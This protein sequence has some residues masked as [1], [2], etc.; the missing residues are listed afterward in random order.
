[1]SWKL[2]IVESPSKAKTIQK[3]LGKSY[4]V[5][6]SFGHVRD[7]L[8]KNK[9]VE[10]HD[11]EVILHYVDGEKSV[12]HLKAI[13]A[14][15]KKTETLI[16]ATDPDR[17]G[18]AIAFHVVEYLKQH[19]DINKIKIERVCFYEITPSKVKDAIAQSRDI[20]MDLVD[21]QQ[22]RRALDYLVGF[23]LSPVLWKKVGPK[24]SAGRVQ[25][26]ALRM[27]KERDDEIQKFKPK[28]YW[29]L[30][31]LLKAG[32]IQIESVTTHLSGEKLKKFS[33]SNEEK[34]VTAKEAITAQSKNTCVV[35][36]IKSK[37]RQRKPAPP[38]I[39]ST[40]Q[41][42][43]ARKLGFSALNTMRIAQQL[44]EGIDRGEST[45][46]LITYMRTDSVTLSGDAIK[47]SRE[48]I[49]SFYGKD[50]LPAK[51]NTYKSKSK[52]AQE[53]HEAIRPVDFSVDPESIKKTLSNDQY[54]LYRLIWVRALASQMKAATFEDQVMVF[55]AK[56]DHLFE[57]RRSQPVFMGFL[58]VYQEGEDEGSKISPAVRHDKFIDLKE[59]ATLSIEDIRPDQHFTE[60]P[61]RFSEASLVKELE[62]KG[63]GRPSTY[64]SII[65]TL[66]AREYVELKQKRFYPTDV[67]SIV[68]EFLNKYFSQYVDYGFTAD[69]ENILDE[70]SNGKRSWQE[71]IRDFWSP[72]NA[73]VDHITENVSKKEVTE[74]K[75]DEKC[76]ECQAD[77]VKKFGKM[78][79]FIACSAYPDCK[80]T[81]SMD[82]ES[83]SDLP[84]IDRACPKC[85][86]PLTYKRGRYGVFIGCTGY[87]DCRHIESIKEKA[88]DQKTGVT[89][90]ECNKGEMVKK[91]SRR[92]TF[93]YSC[94]RY[95]DCKTALSGFPV[96]KQ[97]P[98]CQ[99]PILIIKETKKLGKHLSC[100]QKECKHKEPY[101][102]TNESPSDES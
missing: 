84:E 3:Y 38:F 46:G 87:P 43:A 24:L 7:L 2:M 86:K 22:A 18:E 101:D 72:F 62:A 30:H 52:N 98:E 47:Q 64:A 14:K 100:S 70:I 60:P 76:P 61:A 17:E 89:C 54:K 20:D 31:P 63:I 65:S 69:L 88:A 92:G 36:S 66:K 39:T 25:S 44:F 26:P 102:D 95:P 9:A 21:A 48:V 58:S 27:I 34:A 73:L 45:G 67:G 37:K 79:S 75:I 12:E 51:A 41:Q 50:F 55:Q 81:R 96:A 56:G 8:P 74:E 91:R 85:E 80:Y 6:A 78:G 97:C 53:A 82:G 5:M 71:V 23:S 1:M 13:L 33:L 90:P 11:D 93:F 49:E 4:H 19:L 77:L 32:A 68:A 83:T 59:G 94:S 10:V 99:Y 15:A 35:L 16:L 57:A 40:L 29:S 28:E 42:E